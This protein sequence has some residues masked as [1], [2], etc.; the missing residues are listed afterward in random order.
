MLPKLAHPAR[1]KILVC[2]RRWRKSTV[3]LIASIAGHGPPEKLHMGAMQGGNIWWITPAFPQAQS[4]WLALRGT[5][6]DYAKHISEANRR[7]LLPTGGA[8]TIK[9]AGNIASL[10][11]DMRGLDGVV[12]DE[13][14]KYDPAVWQ[15]A[16]APAITDRKAWTIWPSTP[17]GFNWFK[18]IYDAAEENQDWARWQEPSFAN[19]FW[20]P[21]EMDARRREG[22]PESRIRQEFYAEF[23]LMGPGRTYYEFDRAT[24]IKEWEYDPTLPLD[25]C[26]NFKIAPA[27]WLVVQGDIRNGK[28]ERAIDEI[29][30]TGT[31]A[32]LRALHEEFAR[33][34][35]EHADGRNVRVWGDA[36]PSINGRSTGPS[37]YE[38]LR[39]LFPRA[40]RVTNPVVS[41]P[42]KDRTNV[43]NAALRDLAGQVNATVDPVCVNLIR[44]LEYT[45]NTD[46]SFTVDHSEPGRGHYAHAWS[47]KLLDTD[48]QLA[49]KIRPPPREERKDGHRFPAANPKARASHRAV[50]R[51]VKNGTLR[52]PH[53]CEECGK[54]GYVEA[55]HFNYDEPLRVRWLCK[56]CH[57]RWDFAEPKGGT[58]N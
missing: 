34:Y 47:C 21:A 16:I 1:H 2:G 12:L 22:M 58:L 23:I 27:A 30:P 50:E 31:D 5:L 52:K 8:I 15:Q 54:S 4:A 10:V 33:R 40:K 26:V 39:A 56:S 32:S 17:E 35:P 41:F 29:T 42:E 18:E 36:S 7:I 11:G 55:A 28:P 45:R 53:C 3:A 37:D 57:N 25:L 46:A 14:A 48:Y 49:S 13:A 19:P 24:H 6:K 9:S 38:Y 43:I 20:D 44:D 51:A